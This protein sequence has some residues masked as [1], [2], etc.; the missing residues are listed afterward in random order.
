MRRFLTVLVVAASTTLLSSMA[1][2][3]DEQV[4]EQIAKN[5]RSSGR[6]NEYKIAVNYEDGT[7]RLVGRVQNREQMVTAMKL[8][9]ETPGVKRVVNNMTIAPSDPK[10]SDG[11]PPAQPAASPRANLVSHM[12]D[13]GATS[14][15]TSGPPQTN[16]P[17]QTAPYPAQTT[18]YPVQT[19]PYVARTAPRPMR[20]DGG[21]MAYR[22]TRGTQPR[23]V[24]INYVQ[25][26]PA[27]AVEVPASGAPMPMYT[28]AAA[29]AG[30]A[31]I[32]YDRPTLPNYAWPSYAAYPNYAAVTYPK[33]YSPTA[34]PFI[35]PFYPY[36]QVPLGWRKVSLEWDDGW[37]MLD[38]KDRPS[39]WEG[40]LGRWY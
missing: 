15:A 3:G 24:P 32:R 28:A 16:H 19:A 21:R 17:A 11:N 4:A 35:G 25:G 7:A 14:P 26:E 10:Q 37:W 30:V 34:W 22:S 38:F 40:P 9:I 8:A 33:Q 20:E 1:W 6:L 13:A 27:P 29:Y 36:P 31:P 2:A 23:P 12:I 5:I 18:P 39:S